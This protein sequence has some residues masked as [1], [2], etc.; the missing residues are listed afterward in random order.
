MRTLR[1]VGNIASVSGNPDVQTIIRDLSRLVNPGLEAALETLE[2]LPKLRATE[3]RVRSGTRSGLRAAVRRLVEDAIAEVR[4]DAP[5]YA[6]AADDLLV[7]GPKTTDAKERRRAAGARL[8]KTGPNFRRHFEAGVLASVGDAIVTLEERASQ[9]P[10][11]VPR[12]VDVPWQT[13]QTTL[14]AMHRT[15]EQSFE[16]DAVITMSGPGSFAAFLCLAMDARDVP[17]IACTT[18]P[19]RERPT[20]SHRVYEL[21]ARDG[22]WHT[23]CTSKWVVYLPAV[24]GSFPSRSRILLFD[25]RVVSGDTQ[26]EVRR[27]L[28]EAGYDVRTAAMIV[29]SDSMQRVDFYGL[30][31]DDDY[32]LPWGT[33]RGRT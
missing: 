31:I 11:A 6:A 13:I 33:K 15:I 26:R 1:I 23:V 28:E 19:Y 32:A 10:P 18:F 2:L 9:E 3:Q 16:P 20:S 30:V 22:T 14:H 21:A 4:A 25:D 8:G 7:L 24:V 17:V 12:V 27:L 5:E 29:G